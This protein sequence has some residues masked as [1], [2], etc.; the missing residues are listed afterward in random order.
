MIPRLWAVV[1]SLI[2]E[3]ITTF[4]CGI[5]WDFDIKAG[6]TVRHLKQKYENIVL[7]VI[8]PCDY[9]YGS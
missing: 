7:H 1:E 5:K 9:T 8:V 2:Q 4:I 6:Y 3:G